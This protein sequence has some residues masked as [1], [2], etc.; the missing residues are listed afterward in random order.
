MIIAFLEDDAEQAARV[1]SVLESAGH[2]LE[3]FDRGRNLLRRL[4]TDSF[5]LLILDW[6]VPDQ[7]GLEVLRILRLQLATRTPV[8]FLTHRDEESDVVLALEN[9]ADDYM[10]KPPRER[11]LLSRVHALER[12]SRPQDAAGLVMQVG[13]YRLDVVQR[14][15]DR[16]GARIELTRREFDIAALLFANAGKVLSRAHILA[17]V[18]G[19]GDDV[20]TRTIDTHVSRLRASLGLSAA[21]GVRLTPVYGYGYRLEATAPRDGAG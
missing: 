9:G 12:R 14:R 20:S 3:R 8:L 4:G 1:V 18:W 21:A 13:P 15:I 5:D 7:S 10:V 17:A 11:E 2:V 16:D 6:E 19:V